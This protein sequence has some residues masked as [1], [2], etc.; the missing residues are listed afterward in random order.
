MTGIFQEG[1]SS[2]VLPEIKRLRMVETAFGVGTRSWYKLG[3]DT[4]R[5]YGVW[6]GKSLPET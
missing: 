2:S 1:T 3:G 5:V 4:G 6:P